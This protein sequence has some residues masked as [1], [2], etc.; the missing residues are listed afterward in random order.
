MTTL[1][2]ILIILFSVQSIVWTGLAKILSK[3]KYNNFEPRAF[4]EKLSGK[5][6]RAYWAHL[7]SNEAFPLFVTAI[8]CANISNVPASIIHITAILILVSR[9]LYGVMYIYNYA[10]LRSL[11]WSFG[12]FA[13]FYLLIKCVI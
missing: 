8:I 13:N 9:L 3:E 2:I 1:S 7:N 11:V 12:Y 4:L 6:Q 10:N 5:E